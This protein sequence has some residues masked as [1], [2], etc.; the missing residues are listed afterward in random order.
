VNVLPE[1]V[2]YEPTAAQAL[3]AVHDTPRRPLA[4]VPDGLGTASTAQVAPFHASANAWRPALFWYPPTARQ[5]FVLKT[6]VHEVGA[7][8][9]P[10]GPRNR[11]S[12]ALRILAI[13]DAQMHPQVTLFE[14]YSNQDVRGCCNCLVHPGVPL[15]FLSVGA[16]SSVTWDCYRIGPRW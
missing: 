14:R 9:R 1:A 16:R 3:A 8:K 12:Q 2:T 7:D 10:P 13:G 6:G 4:K 15:C 5:A 11:G